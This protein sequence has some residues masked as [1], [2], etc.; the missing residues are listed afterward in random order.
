MTF[1]SLG[2][3]EPIIR[4]LDNQGYKIPS[5]IQ[6]QAIPA[7]L[8]GQDLMATAQ[9][10]TGKTAAFALPLLQM[11]SD[12]KTA[13]PAQIQALVLTP[14]RELA[15]QVGKSFQSFGQHLAL[16][17]A[18]IFGGVGIGPQKKQLRK[19]VNILVATPGRLLDLCSQGCIDL[20]Q[21]SYFVLDEADRMLDM[22][23]IPD[24]RRIM[25]RLP[26]RRQNLLF[27]AT[28]ST[29]IRQL[30]KDLTKSPVQIEVASRNSA[31]DNVRQIIHPV[32]KLQ[33]AQLLCR[34]IQDGNWDQVL[35]FTRTKH[36][37]NQ[38]TSK[39]EKAGISA[40]AI[41]GNK[42]QGSRT[43]TLADFKNRKIR[44]LV[45]TD[46]ASRGLDI[47]RLPQVVNYE[48]PDVAEDYIHRVGRTG[49]AGLQGNAV[50][51][52]SVD[53]QKSLIS[54]ERL[55]NKALTC[56]VIDGFELN[57]ENSV[58][59]PKKDAPIRRRKS[60]LNRSSLPSFKKRKTS[61]WK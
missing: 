13:T 47:Q 4:A 49:R 28:F 27:S 41:H 17:V 54:I 12:Q 14:T 33:K 15:V 57:L 35:V 37:A 48:L 10:G 26:H 38:L 32:D 3:T 45:A 25:K 42:S 23:F 34:L 24:I 7:I 53:E 5:P 50:S 29:K 61:H 60:T 21:V 31:S 20:S 44:A 2:I 46:I 40:A 22:G 55:L 9:T 39:L 1:N 43:R 16:K 51:L 52:V 6:T 11:L 59:T 58:L 18:T 8:T 56:E 19:G 36:R 30:A